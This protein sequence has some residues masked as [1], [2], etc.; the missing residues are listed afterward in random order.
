LAPSSPAAQAPGLD[1][2]QA[3]CKN[4]IG[5]PSLRLIIAS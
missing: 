2:L 4:D 5:W 3:E 1:G